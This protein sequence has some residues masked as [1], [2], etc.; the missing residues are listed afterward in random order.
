MKNQVNQIRNIGD[1]GVITKPEGSVKISVLNNSRQI[2]VVVAG[3]GKD[4]KPGWMTMKVLPESGLPK[5]IN[6]LDE[7][8]NPAKNMRTQK[9]GGQVLHVDQAHVYQ[10]GPKGLVKHDRNI[11][12]V[13][14]QGKEPIVGRWALLQIVGGDKLIIPFC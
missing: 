12:A 9:Y 3:A 7:A 2:D 14:L 13:G 10:F 5:G 6:Y 8:I 11:F 4:G 1:A